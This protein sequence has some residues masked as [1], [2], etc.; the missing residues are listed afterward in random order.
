M[1][2]WEEDWQDLIREA[3]VPKSRIRWETVGP[4]IGWALAALLVAVLTLLGLHLLGI[5]LAWL[6]ITVLKPVLIFVGW[7]LLVIIVICFAFAVG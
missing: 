2:Q 4:V 1:E 7:C 5:F 6:W 3:Q